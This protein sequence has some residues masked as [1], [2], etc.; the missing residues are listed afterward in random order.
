M[1]DSEGCAAAF[2]GMI[3][4]AVVTGFI[5]GGIT[6]AVWKQDMIRRGLMRYNDTTGELHYTAKAGGTLPQQK[7]Q[8]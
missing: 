7:G 5:V 4:G 2:G 3:A 8:E 1:T 6:N